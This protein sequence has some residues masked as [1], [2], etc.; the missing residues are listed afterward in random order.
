MYAIFRVKMYALF[1]INQ[2]IYIVEIKKVNASLRKKRR[3]YIVEC[4]KCEQFLDL[5]VNEL[6]SIKK[7]VYIV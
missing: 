5:Q 4:K 1:R 7:R 6:F 3:V 2:R